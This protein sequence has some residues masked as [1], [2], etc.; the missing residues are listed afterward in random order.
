MWRSK[1]PPVGDAKEEMELKAG[2]FWEAFDW[3]SQ[4]GPPPLLLRV[5]QLETYPV[6]K[7]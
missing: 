5:K 4:V 1:R 6:Q 7:Q 3:L 2:L